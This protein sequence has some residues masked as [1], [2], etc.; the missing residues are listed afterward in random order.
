MLDKDPASRLTMK[1]LLSHEW[2]VQEITNNFDFSS[3]VPCDDHEAHPDIYYSPGQVFSNATALSTSH[4]SLSLVDDESICDDI[5]EDFNED[6]SAARSVS[7]RSK[8]GNNLPTLNC[9]FGD[10]ES[11]S[12]RWSPQCESN[13]KMLIAN[14]SDLSSLSPSNSNPPNLSM[15]TIDLPLSVNT[16]TTSKSEN[17]IFE[18]N[19]LALP[20]Y[21]P[22]NF[23]IVSSLSDLSD[24][25]S[26]YDRRQMNDLSKT[27]VLNRFSD[28]EESFLGK[29]DRF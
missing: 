27:T 7:T 6:L 28:D 10:T 25:A 9:T 19:N 14:C 21:G 5:D 2:I 13:R 3:I 8:T 23:D 15:V 4:D 18:K 20:P 11:S 22:A 26:F 24:D 1:E 29:N 12:H 17:N 16:L